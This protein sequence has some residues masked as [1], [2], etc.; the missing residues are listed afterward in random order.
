[1][2]QFRGF[3]KGETKPIT[4]QGTNASGLVAGACGWNVGVKLYAFHDSH[5]N[6]DGVEV[7]TTRG[8]SGPTVCHQSIGVMWENDGWVPWQDPRGQLRDGSRPWLD[9]DTS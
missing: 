5:R 6:E 7:V 1:M 9:G 8:S 4:R 2:A 3:L